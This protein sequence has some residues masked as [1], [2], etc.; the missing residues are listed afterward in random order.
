MYQINAFKKYQTNLI[1]KGQFYHKNNY[2]K[3]VLYKVLKNGLH[4]DL[5]YNMLLIN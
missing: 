5:F 1:Q 2:N 3:K 4:G